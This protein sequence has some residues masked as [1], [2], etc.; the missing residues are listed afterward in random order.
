M[1]DAVIVA[2]ARTPIGKA[3]RGALNNTEAPTLAAH[4]MKAALARTPLAADE[5]EEVLLGCAVTQGTSGVNIARHAVMAAHW[6]V[7]ISGKTIDQQCASGLSAIASAALQIQS[8]Q[9]R[10][11]LAGGVESVSL[12]Q[13]DKMNNYRLRDPKVLSH[14]PKYYLNMLETAEILAK[15][16]QV[17]REEQDAYALQSQQ[18]AAK[19]KAAGW[20]AKEIAPLEVSQLIVDKDSGQTHQ[21]LR[22]FSEDEGLRETRIDALAALKPALANGTCVTAGNA[23]QLS[24]G[25]CACLLMSERE[26]EQR[27]ITPLGRLRDM[28]SVGLAPEEMG[29]GPLH[30]IPKLLARNQLTVDAIDLWEINEA[31]ACQVLACV[32]R[33]GIDQDKLNVNGGA[34]ALGHPYGMSGARLAGHA[35]LEGARRGAKRVLVSL[36][37]GGGMG[38]AALFERP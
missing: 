1:Q 23:S 11:L 37:V 20:F 26:A 18:R 6:P 31:F 13:N 2:T 21:K 28:V 27:G 32:Q 4:A 35:L 9:N 36:C 5:I 25:A 7:S 17:S 33:L 8:G 38:V 22:T 15:R 12:A 19:A 10:I 14:Y 3:Y 30:A 24:D 29:M 34:I 16:Y